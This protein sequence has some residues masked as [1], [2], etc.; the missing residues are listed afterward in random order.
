[1]RSNRAWVLPVAI[2]APRSRHWTRMPSSSG[3][4]RRDR[5]HGIA[6]TP[7][8]EA[9]RSRSRRT[10]RG[11]DGFGPGPL[12][13]YRVFARLRLVAIGMVRYLGQAE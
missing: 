4:G 6:G 11:D 9:A 1:M 8:R 13:R 10:S 3:L 2:A 12:A 7:S 5:T